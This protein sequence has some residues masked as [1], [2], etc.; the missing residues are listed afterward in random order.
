MLRLKEFYGRFNLEYNY[1]E[2]DYREDLANIENQDW[3]SKY[4]RKDDVRNIY[5][6]WRPLI[7]SLIRCAYPDQRIVFDVL[8]PKKKDRMR[9]WNDVAARSI[10]HLIDNFTNNQNKYC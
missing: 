6:S 1:K 2:G 4:F 8:S 3:L 10:G 5:V 9:A 7:D